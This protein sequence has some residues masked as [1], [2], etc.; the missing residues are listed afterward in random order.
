MANS[1]IYNEYVNS[2]GFESVS[3]QPAHYKKQN[4]SSGKRTEFPQQFKDT[5]SAEKL[6]LT[7]NF[8]TTFCDGIAWLL[9]FHKQIS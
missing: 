6:G 8:K 9:N 5:F 7:C 4:K 2:L 1:R 3:L